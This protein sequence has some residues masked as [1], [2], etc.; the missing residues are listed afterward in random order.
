VQHRGV[1]QAQ[2][3]AT[4]A[5][6]LARRDREQRFDALISACGAL[7]ERVRRAV[8]THMA[9]LRQKI[10]VIA[11]EPRHLITVHRVGYKFAP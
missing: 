2:G 8:D 1:D 5:Q 4:E 6:F 10:E 7:H 9:R 11:A 3:F